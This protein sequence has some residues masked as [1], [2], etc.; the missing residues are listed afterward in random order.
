MIAQMF[1][2]VWNRKRA[3]VLL[4]GELLCAFLVVFAVA[5]FGLYYAHNL[6]RP[7][8]FE[9]EN[10]WSIYCLPDFNV[11]TRGGD[12]KLGPFYKK[13][14]FFKILAFF[15]YTNRAIF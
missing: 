6:R 7:L 10:V 3:N 2:L 4:I 11:L 8:G 5:T 12:T 14:Y 1:K 13:I 9:Y 15:I